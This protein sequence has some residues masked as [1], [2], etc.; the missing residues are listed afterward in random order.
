MAT[1][2][3]EPLFFV[4]IAVGGPVICFVT[5]HRYHD[6]LRTFFVTHLKQRQ[7]FTS[8]MFMQD[9]APIHIHKTMKE[10]LFQRFTGENDFSRF[11]PKPRTTHSLDLILL[12]WH[13]FIG[14]ILLWS[15][16]KCLMYR[17]GIA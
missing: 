2:I 3:P 13:N 4:V 14:A 17:G 12:H 10:L 5:G 8:T 11:F 9:D 15:H 7:I 16:L 1:F 6:M